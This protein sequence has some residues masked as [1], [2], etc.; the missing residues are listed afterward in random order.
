[1]GGEEA[2]LRELTKACTEWALYSGFGRGVGEWI[3]PHKQQV[4]KEEKDAYIERIK[5]EALDHEYNQMLD[6]VKEELEG[7][8]LEAGSSLGLD[9]G[10]LQSWWSGEFAPVVSEG[11]KEM[12]RSDCPAF[13]LDIDM[14][15]SMLSR[16]YGRHG[17]MSPFRD[18]LEAAAAGRQHLAQLVQGAGAH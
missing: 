7:S 2:K 12:V 10:L 13:G 8:D 11:G 17:N 6:N 4:I 14:I 3:E 18:V 15:N 5:D 1:M 9:E 16:I